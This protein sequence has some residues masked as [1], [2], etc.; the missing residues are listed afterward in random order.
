[1]P[2][3]RIAC[4]P[5]ANTEPVNGWDCAA[6]VGADRAAGDTR[7]KIVGRIRT[8]KLVDRVG[9]NCARV[10]A[11]L[12]RTTGRNQ[13]RRVSAA[14]EHLDV[15]VGRIVVRSGDDTGA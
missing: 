3:E 12:N 7:R 9:R 10:N 1:M 13:E 11:G 8:R 4:L 2:A 6:G 14:C 15:V 5:R